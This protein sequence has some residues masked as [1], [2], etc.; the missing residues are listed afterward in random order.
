M[1]HEY[2]ANLIPFVFQ[3]KIN[4][5][6]IYWK[7]N[8][9]ISLLFSRGRGLRHGRGQR[10]LSSS[11]STSTSSL[12]SKHFIPIADGRNSIALLNSGSSCS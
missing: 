6:K 1:F 5:Q 9:N 12:A 4:Q 3:N 8:G 11:S 10:P 2:L 7:F